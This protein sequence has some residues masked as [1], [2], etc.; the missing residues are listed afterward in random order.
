MKTLVGLVTALSVP[1]MV[2]NI[3]GAIV[4]GIW[5]AVLK[6]WG[7]LGLGVGLFVIST[8]ALGI[9]LMPSLLFDAP[10]AMCAERGK[11]LGLFFFSTLSALYTLALITIWCCAIVFV[12]M[13]GATPATYVPR[14]IWSY[15]IATGPWAYMASH[16][17][18]A[19]PSGLGSTF[20]TFLAEL[21]YLVIMLIVFISGISLVG[22]IEVFG[23]FMLVALIVQIT[24]T[25]IVQREQHRLER[26]V[27]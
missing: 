2:L 16:D 17:R 13:K 24:V 22:A 20:A 1:L 14:L 19:G 26:Q 7:A 18:A 8:F 11:T 23:T 21:A 15:G 25:V 12:F 9:A 4:S 5:L 6:D 10:A 3:L 27:L